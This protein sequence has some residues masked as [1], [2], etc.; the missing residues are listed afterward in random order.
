LSTPPPRARLGWFE[1]FAPLGAIVFGIWVAIGFFMAPN[2]GETSESVLRAAHDHE[3]ENLVSQ[4][5][6]LAAPIL[7]GWFLA[8]LV[9]RM[10][11]LADS[12]PRTLTLV[13]GTLFVGFFTIAI[14]LWTAPLLD[15]DSL[16]ETQAQA[17][18]AFDDVGWV[19]LGA[20]GVA[21]GVMIIGASLAALRLGWGPRWVGI[22]SLLLGIASF[23]TVAFVGLFAW[24]AWLILAGLLL[25]VWGERM[26]EGAPA[27]V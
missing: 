25:L 24:I 26:R 18:L 27:P 23:A 5:A 10:R 20:A 6:A 13:G 12:L 7:I 11:P 21:A 22:V 19:L 3:A 15:A 2:N 8:G 14:T 1:R 17:Y 9:A 16:N 4:L